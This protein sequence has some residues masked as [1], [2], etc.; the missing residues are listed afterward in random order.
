[1]ECIDLSA[2]VATEGSDLLELFVKTGRMQELVEAFASASKELL[3][4]TSQ[5]Q[6]IGAKSK[7]L[8][9]MGWTPELWNVKP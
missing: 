8:R 5:K 3:I 9:A 7:K 1:M 4:L 2:V 6:S